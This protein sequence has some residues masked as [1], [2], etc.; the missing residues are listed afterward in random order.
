MYARFA[1]ERF[2]V[3]EER[4]GTVSIGGMMGVHP[5][6]PPQ[7]SQVFL[8]RCSVLYG[9]SNRTVAL[10]SRYLYMFQESLATSS[11]VRE[12]QQCS[13]RDVSHRSQ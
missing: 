7:L 2:A 12:S 6:T 4:R 1:S 9:L 8:G 10:V 13:D 3:D 5:L 11:R